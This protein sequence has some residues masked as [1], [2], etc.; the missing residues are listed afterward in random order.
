MSKN[1]SRVQDIDDL[2]VDIYNTNDNFDEVNGMKKSPE[3]NSYVNTVMPQKNDGI[4]WFEKVCFAIAGMSFQIQ[5]CALG[6]FSSVFL[7]NIA[8]LPPEKNMFRIFFCV[9]DIKY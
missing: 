1:K 8:K 2:E 4:S 7:L 9:N 6:V 5:F 3:S